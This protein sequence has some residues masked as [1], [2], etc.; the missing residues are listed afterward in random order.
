MALDRPHLVRGVASGR[1]D[2]EQWSKSSLGQLAG[3]GGRAVSWRG[4]SAAAAM[5]GKAR[6]VVVGGGVAGALLA[7]IMQGHA[8][9]VLLDP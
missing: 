9:V 3:V 4:N 1:R 7:K 8:D 2:A 5:S 6:V